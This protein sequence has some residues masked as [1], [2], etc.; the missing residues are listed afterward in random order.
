MLVLRPL[1]ARAAWLGLLLSLVGI[2]T[3]SHA[4]PF[5]IFQEDFDGYTSFP[6]TN[7]SGDYVN[8][9]L[10]SVSEG[11]DETWYGA[12]FAGSGSTASSIADDLFVQKCGDWT[13]VNCQNSGSLNT[14]PVGRFE[15]DA[16]I[17]LEISTLG[18]TDVTLNFD[19]RT[20]STETSDSFRAGYIASDTPIS[21]VS[22]AGGGYADLRTGAFAWSNWTELVSGRTSPFVSAPTFGLP[23]DEAYVYVAFWL[24]D[25]EGDH[26]KVDNV[27]IQAS[28][29]P[30]PTTALLFGLG[31]G[32][33]AAL[34]PRRD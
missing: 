30:E 34:R 33:L 15:D 27:L 11:A 16:G 17:L 4:L 13:G 1:L 20:F 12:R 31:L 2:D 6:T 18:L 5:T 8:L 14:S 26:G 7:P 10:P 29:I 3:P 28:L 23:G 19:W 24:D 22:F 25:G 32:G 9:G 21:F